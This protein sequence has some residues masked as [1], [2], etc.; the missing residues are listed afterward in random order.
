MR[1]VMCGAGAIGGV[2]GGQLAKAGFAVI[3]IDKIPEHVAA[4]NTQGLLLKGVHGT[5]RLTI[6]AVLQASAVDF[7]P[8]DVIVLAVKS[9]HCAAAVAELRR[10]TTLELPIFCAQ[11]GVA[12]ESIAARSFQHVHGLMVLIGA[13]CLVPGEVVHTGNG[14]VGIGTYPTGLSQAAQEVAAALD[15]TDLPIYTTTRIDQAKW[16]KLLINLNNATLGLTGCATQEAAAH[17]PTRAWMAEVWAEGAR[18]LQAA[19]I[20]YAGPPGMGPIEDRIRELRDSNV[21]P[22]V[23][24]D[25]A[26]TGRSSLWQDLYHRRGEVEA[27]YLNG[28]IVRLGH[29][30]GVPTPYNSLLLELSTAMAVARERPGKYTVEQ[31]W[32]RLQQ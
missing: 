21:A 31:L 2:L 3:C 27:E 6:P 5:H 7:R 9:F 4:I 24:V 10:A 26:D 20:A 1:F 32:E 25:D 30:H 11:N 15:E 12:S 18:V 23:P 17:T 19:G 29:Q 14:P 16:N 8:D 28:A 13:K 22:Y